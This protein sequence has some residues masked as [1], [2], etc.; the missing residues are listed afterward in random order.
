M[1]RV[2]AYIKSRPDFWPHFWIGSVAA[3]VGFGYGV[4]LHG[5]VW[6]VLAY[7]VSFALIAGIAIEISQSLGW[8]RKGQVDY[9]DV[10][11]TA[12]GALPVILAIT[13]V[14]VLMR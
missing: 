7:A 11:H 4:Y 12:A 14:L 3:L 8:P 6:L 9:T 13:F 5:L 10:L 2:T 1:V